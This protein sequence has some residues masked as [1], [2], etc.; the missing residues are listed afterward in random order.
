VWAVSAETG[1][2]IWNYEQ[3]TG[4]FSLVT[5]GGGLVLVPRKPSRT[6]A[7]EYHLAHAN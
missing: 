5:T 6:H 2:T 3:R 4:V 1:K 7:L